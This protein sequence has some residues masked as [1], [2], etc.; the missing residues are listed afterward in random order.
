MTILIPL[1]V[2]AVF[3]ISWFL[4]RS[5]WM[6]AESRNILD[7]PGDRSSH[8]RPTARGGGLAIVL[9]VSVGLVSV[10][11]WFSPAGRQVL[12][13]YLA[14]AWLIASVSWID[15]LRPLSYRLRLAVQAGASFLLIVQLGYWDALALPLFGVVELGWLGPLIT[16]L[17]L[18]GMTNAYNFMDGIDGMAG[19]Q[20]VVA[21]VGWAVLGVVTGQPLLLFL[22]GVLAASSLGF[23]AHN[24]QPARI[25]MGD[26]GSAFL[27]FTLAAAVLAGSKVDL[28]LTVAGVLILWPFV[29]DTA[30]TFLRRLFH[31]E[32]V[33]T[34]H[35]SHLYQR[36]V[37]A[38]FSHRFVA[39]LYGG[40]ASV[41]VVLAVGWVIMWPLIDAI[42]VVMIPLCCLMLWRF[43]VRS[44]SRRLRSDQL[45]TTSAPASEPGI[46]SAG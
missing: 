39:G 27:G 5:L 43:V 20:A 9:I 8:S 31:G 38:G 19:L 3:W 41:G 40:L 21:G 44:E 35:R 30:M 34:A 4:V 16:F 37:I 33:F 11:H 25:F 23:L 13:I 32:D 15:D 36:L 2:V 17:W 14:A 42:V 29:F 24:W 10:A 12:V 18:V 28:R 45:L 22:G 1:A 46:G 6:W 26:V 7:R